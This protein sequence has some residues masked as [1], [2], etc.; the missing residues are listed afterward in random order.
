MGVSNEIDR[1]VLV[2]G[3]LGYIGSHTVVEL[4]KSGY[5][6]VIIDNLSNTSIENL[7]GARDLSGYEIPFHQIDCTLHDQLECVFASYENI[8]GVIHFAAFKSVE[9]SVRYPD[10]YY[11]N[12]LESLKTLLKVSNKFSVRNLIFS[13]SCTV[14]GSPDRLP[15]TE[16]TPFQDPASPYAH[17]KQL[18]ERIIEENDVNSVSLRYFNPIG[19]DPSGRIGDRSFDHPT[20][21]VPIITETAIGERDSLIINGNDYNTIDGTC[22]RDYIHVLDVAQS[23]VSALNYL[24]INSGKHVFNIGI[25]SGISVLQMIQAFEKANDVLVNFTIGPK[26]KGDISEIFSDNTMAYKY[27]K[28][29]PKQSIEQALKD[30]WTWQLKK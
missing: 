26:R 8:I 9:E 11:H 10:K 20:N 19:S 16:D 7:H 24:L 4:V 2:T 1:Y 25:G 22:V 13:S 6:P 18:C 23:H 30:S 21:L 15:V 29:K 28:W 17:S 3:G 27:L 12:N 14:Y 5:K